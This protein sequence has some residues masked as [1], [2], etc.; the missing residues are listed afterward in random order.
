MLFRRYQ[1]A[2]QEAILALHYQAL[3]EV[4]ITNRSKE[5]NADLYNIEKVY[6]Q[7]GEF[8]INDFNGMIIAMGG[9]KPIN[10]NTAQIVRLR[11]HPLYRRKGIG[12]ALLKIL[13]TNAKKSGYRKVKLDTLILRKAAQNFYIKNGYREV[14]RKRVDEQEIMVYQ[15]RL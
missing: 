1:P 5:K 6:L 3:E 8:L 9:L 4:G 12:T 7:R 2:D 13:E 15:K 14:Q 10:K 11:V